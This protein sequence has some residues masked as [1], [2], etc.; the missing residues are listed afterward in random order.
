M[1]NQKMTYHIKETRT[2]CG[3]SVQWC[4]KVDL[5]I[6]RSKIFQFT[7]KRER[8]IITTRNEKWINLKTF[9][10]KKSLKVILSLLGFE[11]DELGNYAIYVYSLKLIERERDWEK[12]KTKD[13]LHI[14]HF[15]C[16]CTIIMLTFSQLRSFN[17][18]LKKFTLWLRN[19][20]NK[21]WRCQGRIT[22]IS[23]EMSLMLVELCSFNF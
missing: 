8:E 5:Y 2:N 10:I 3:N 21:R 15:A 1:F 17:V 16:H 7:N 22:A 18:Y 4:D 13:D 14:L 23:K 20:T 11:L 19:W 9:Y 12:M 6:F